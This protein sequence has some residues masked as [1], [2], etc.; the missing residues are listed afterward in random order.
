MK[1]HALFTPNFSGIIG[2]CFSLVFI[3]FEIVENVFLL[4]LHRRSCR[5]AAEFVTG[6]SE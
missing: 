1:S 3:R 6:F 2:I 4:L 5:F